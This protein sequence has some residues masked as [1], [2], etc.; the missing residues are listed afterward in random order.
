MNI[1]PPMVGY[2]FI[3]T[4]VFSLYKTICNFILSQLSMFAFVTYFRGLI[5]REGLL[6]H[7]RLN[8]PSLLPS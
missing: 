1:F 6:Y 3:L 5:Q 4:V 2:V 7:K 8:Y